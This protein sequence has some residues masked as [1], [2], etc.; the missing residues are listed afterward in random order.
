MLLK[1]RHFCAGLALLLA[2]S[3]NAAS[4]NYT[5]QFT[6][7]SGT[8]PTSGSFTYDSTTSLF[9]NFVVAWDIYN[10]DL[11]AAANAPATG[12]T[13][14]AGCTD[15]NGATTF[16]L[17]SHQCGADGWVANV[18]NAGPFPFAIHWFSFQ[19][20]QPSWPPTNLAAYAT[21]NHSG[22]PNT[23]TGA[24]NWTITPESAPDAAVPEPGSLCLLA[25]GAVAALALRR[26]V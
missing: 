5:I 1:I 6:T 22:S 14:I 15:S 13:A 24:G 2:A 7:S 25:T 20:P 8:A 21:V 9:S 16:Q 19:I 17:L 23:R 11:T 3:A 4:I 10:F 26:Q 12:G 18:T